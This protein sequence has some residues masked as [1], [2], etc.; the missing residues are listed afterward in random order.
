MQPEPDYYTI[1]QLPPGA[2]IE[3]VR[4]QYR[5]L[6][7]IFHPDRNSGDEWCHEQTKRINIAFEFLSN[8]ERKA[9][10][11]ARYERS[12]TPTARTY[13]AA[14][15][16]TRR[17]AKSVNRTPIAR[18]PRYDFSEPSSGRSRWVVT[19][20]WIAVTVS[21]GLFAMAI[22]RSGG[23]GGGMRQMMLLPS[24][25]TGLMAAFTGG[26][27]KQI[28][29]AYRFQLAVLTDSAQS[30]MSDA[31][32]TLT[33]LQAEDKQ[34][35]PAN[36]QTEADGSNRNRIEAQLRAQS[37]ALAAHLKIASQDVDRFDWT[38]PGVRRRLHASTIDEDIQQI[39]DSIE[40]LHDTVCTA[41]EM[42]ISRDPFND[43]SQSS[44]P[45]PGT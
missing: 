31:H 18:M 33:E 21:V 9:V 24:L 37:A 5:R 25:H 16:P 34:V 38:T 32:D 13:K 23:N 8:S 43:S 39:D 22:I 11:D 12:T 6:A 4:D 7:K 30:G 28:E 27:P 14:L 20:S 44:Q 42:I 19:A 17:P 29:R 41:Q 10:Y 45:T 2:S 3:T 36:K 1:L 40:P 15:N 35:Q 26:G